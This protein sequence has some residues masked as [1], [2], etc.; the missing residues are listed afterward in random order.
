MDNPWDI[1]I[2]TNEAKRILNKA[3]TRIAEL[4]AIETLEEETLSFE[5]A[6]KQINVSFKVDQ[7]NADK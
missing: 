4:E 1:E 6:G 3:L 5:I 2:K 7:S